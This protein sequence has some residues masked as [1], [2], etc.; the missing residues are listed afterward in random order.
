MN[1]NP[2]NQ[3]A[4]VAQRQV[5]VLTDDLDGK[6]ISS[7]TGETIVFG[8]DG[9]TYEIDLGTKN[10]VKLRD[11]FGTYIALARRVSSRRS[12]SR[13]SAN[14]GVD[15]A[16]VRAWATSNNIEVNE[17]GRISRAVIDQFRAAGN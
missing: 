10:A 4:T 12:A 15:P 13:T 6:E 5:V 9:V 3:G 11:T 7:D 16:A 2:L 17:R 1:A 14:S 8:L